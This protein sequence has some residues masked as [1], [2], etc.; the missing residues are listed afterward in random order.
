MPL[1]QLS[2]PL[3][4]ECGWESLPPVQLIVEREETKTACVD[5]VQSLSN[6]QANEIAPCSLMGLTPDKQQVRVPSD[7]D[8]PH[9]M[10]WVGE[11]GGHHKIV[12]HPLG[13]PV[14][15]LRIGFKPC[16]DW[17]IGAYWTSNCFTV[18]DPLAGTCINVA[19]CKYLVGA[20]ASGPFGDGC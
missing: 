2:P 3:L 9:L 8:P 10:V 6:K 12:M 1:R 5:K 13:T 16:L 20:C 4:I 7:P 15:S 17:Q 11:R 18:E 19:V 14:Q